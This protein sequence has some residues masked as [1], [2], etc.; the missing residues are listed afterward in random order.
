M[1]D[2]RLI[3]IPDFDFSG[4][5]YPEIVRA[6]IQFQRA[7]VDEITDESDEE[8]FQQLLRAYALTAHLNNVLLDMVANETLLPTARLLESVRGH[9]ALIDVRLEQASPAQ[10]D[11]VL[12]FSKIFTIA[13]NIVPG[14]S[15][16]ATV[17]TE[18]D[19]QVIYENDD[20]ATIQP[21]DVPTAVFT[22]TAGKIKILDNAFD[23]GDFITIEGVDFRNGIEWAPGGSI[24]ATLDNITAAINAAVSDAIAGK[25]A[26]INDGVATISLIPLAQDVEAI[27]VTES[28]GAADNFEVLSGGFST[29]KTGIYSTDSVFADLF[30]DKPK[31]G[32]M[33]YV[34]HSDVMWDTLE[35]V[36]N[37]VG[38]GLDLAVEFYDDSFEDEKPDTVTNLGANLEFDVSTLL[39]IT[40]RKGTVVR[41]VLSSSGAA[42][43]V[44]SQWS[45]GKNIIQT[46][47]LL[48]QAVVSTDREDYVVGTLWNEVSDTSDASNGLNEDGKLSYTLPQS[49]AQNWTKTTVNSIEGHW[50]RLRVIG[51]TE[52]AATFTGS[53]LTV[54]SLDGSNYNIKV[55]IDAFAATEIDVTGDLGVGGG[56]TIGG[57][58]S[59]INAALAI[60]DPSLSTVASNDGGQIKMTSPTANQAS[61]IEFT[62]P[63]TNDAA[64]EVFGLSEGNYP[65]TYNGVGG[66]PNVDRLRIDTGKQYLL[67]A[68]VQGQTVGDDPLGSS[69]GTADQEFILTHRPLIEGTL[70]LEIDEGAGFQSW[71]Q[72]ENFLSSNSASKDFTLEI[73]ADDIATIKFGDGVQGKI[74]TPGVDNIRAIYRIGA[75]LDGNVGANTIKVNKSGISFV[76][77]MFN[78]RQASGWTTKEGSTEADLARLK[79]EGPATLRTRG[80]AIA[81]SDFEFLATQYEASTGSKIVARALAIEETFGV[82]T[83]ELVVVGLGGVILTEAERD[84]LAEYFNGNRVVGVD[85]VIVTNHQV[86]VVNYTQKIIDVTAEVV[87]GNQT[88]I[89][90][91][92][93]ALLN[94]EATFDD[95]VTKRWAFGQ[96]V[97]TSVIVAEIF[98]VSPENIK[99]VTMTV[100]AGNVALDARELPFAGNVNVTV[101]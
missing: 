97:P 66:N 8:P 18:D 5:Y 6:L 9:L 59:A 1:A 12:E 17:E 40:N 90:N 45:G 39:G 49:Q 56:Y 76:N 85:P 64:L 58:I 24:A 38:S 101:V 89:E 43:T 100:P 91:A 15:Q 67:V 84:E 93:K 83:V 32:D 11:V 14:N 48:G 31:N 37:V 42:E 36:F 68:V 27:T 80:R 50:L 60:V 74:P 13:T 65:H 10:T 3:E 95:G 62:A 96:E 16:F 20:S 41:V 87:G 81:V 98:E 92:I 55:Q 4:F 33:V 44:I 19:P 99:K 71:N 23:G 47:G 29:N 30:D 22:F 34:A 25:I 75:D 79:I 21:T 88:Q 86:T 94:P 69:N 70:V 63:S 51:F 54:G 61:L 78:P 28:D 2:A 57:I 72:K 35:W 46:S 82:K 52:T 77:R 73:S 26:A 7:N 53:N